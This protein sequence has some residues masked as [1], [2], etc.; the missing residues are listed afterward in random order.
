MATTDDSRRAHVDQQRAKLPDEP[1]VYLYSDV[2]GN[3]LYVGKAKSL[4]KR[5]NSYFSKSHAAKT[6]AL[7]MRVANIEV[8]VLGSEQEAL[9]FEQNLV[10]RHR[11]PFNVMLR[12]DKSYP[13]I[14]VTLA[15]DYPRVLFTRE[16]HRTGVKY[17]GP[18]SNAKRVRQTLDLLN[19]IFPYRPCEGVQPGR[20]SGVP[21]LDY[22]IERCAAPCVGK[23]SQ[24]DYRAVIDQVMQVL[25][26]RSRPIERQLLEQMQQ[27]SQELEFE[28]AAR[29]RN[30][31][32]GLQQ[33]VSLQAVERPGSGSFDVIGA[34]VAESGANVQVLQVRDGRLA[35]RRSHYL[36][37]AECQSLSVVLSQFVLSYYVPGRP[38]PPQ[39]IVEQGA[40][41][42]EDCALVAEELT[43]LRESRV[44]VRGAQRGD[45]RRLVELAARNAQHAL[46]YDSIR[47]RTRAE[48]RAA[49]LEELRDELNLESLPLR[50]ECYDISNL[51]ESAP[52]ASMVVFEE[53]RPKKDHYRKFSM[54]HSGGQDDFAMMAEV[55]ARRFRRLA[56]QPGGAAAAELGN[57]DPLLSAD[58]PPAGEPTGKD[59]SLHNDVEALAQELEGVDC[60]GSSD[61]VPPPTADVD[62]EVVDA[63]FSSI[64]N[65]VVI[66]GGKG[67]LNAAAARLRELGVERVSICSLAK[68]EEEIYLPGRSDPLALE[69]RSPALQVLQQIRNEAHRFAVGYHR[70][71]RSMETTR[72][73]IDVLQ[74]VGPARKRALLIFFGSPERVLRASLDEIESVPGMPGKVARSIYDQ[75]NRLGGGTADSARR[76]SG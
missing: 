26:G 1:G 52:V 51:Q 55:I 60:G 70:T 22:H 61:D 38:I 59:S 75:I 48:R 47:E 50:I 5:V 29:I 63:S 33:V 21:C 73:V 23:I 25:S 2:H 16:T 46:E 11:P 68:R 3:V 13:Y 45:K 17:F 31:V 54:R 7:V 65:L 9:I 6:H 67:Q 12:D 39:V 40:L 15:D 69:R 42:D 35:D 72:S 37:N 71:K 18:Y 30:R 41:T 44:E 64:P 58:E 66:D 4:H 32:R 56:T 34:A 19:R 27:A 36:D 20:Q 74:G 14:A 57:D 43:R 62:E 10:K 49:A 76:S 28:R 24:H 8:F 53:G